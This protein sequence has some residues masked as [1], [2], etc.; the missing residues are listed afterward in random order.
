MP[1][2]NDGQSLTLQG[3][4]KYKNYKYKIVQ[5]MFVFFTFL[6]LIVSSYKVIEYSGLQ[7]STI[8]TLNQLL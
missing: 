8:V 2:I 1:Y 5:F 3:F 4:K 6:L 7:K